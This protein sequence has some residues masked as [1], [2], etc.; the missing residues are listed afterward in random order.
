ME[1]IRP[2]R[3]GLSLD[4]TPMIDIVFQLLIFF[5]LSSSFLHPSMKLTLPKAVTHDSGESEK[6]VITIGKSGEI[7]FNT[8]PVGSG[9]LPNRLALLN[10]KDDNVHI[11]GD[12]E[13]PYKKVIEVLDL[14]RQA[15]I[16]RIHIAHQGVNSK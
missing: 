5:M 1:F 12:A 14:V 16:S 11:Q 2:K 8:H 6:T 7:Y 13:V 10:A 3:V 4:M 15:G 9:E